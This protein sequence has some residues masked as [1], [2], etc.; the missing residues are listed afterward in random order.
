SALRELLKKPL[1][2]WAGVI[3]LLGVYVALTLRTITQSSI[4]FDEGFSAY[5]VR[6]NY[7]DIARYTAADVHPPLYYWALKTWQYAFGSSEAGLRSMSV[8]FAVA[9]M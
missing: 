9:A 4:W 3:G 5:I 6:F 1:A 2:M 8:A 7:W